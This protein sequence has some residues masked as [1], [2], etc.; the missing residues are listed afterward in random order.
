MAVINLKFQEYSGYPSISTWK[1]VAYEFRK[2]SLCSINV[3]GNAI[4]YQK[5]E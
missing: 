5:W 1:G 2:N 3:T 4:M